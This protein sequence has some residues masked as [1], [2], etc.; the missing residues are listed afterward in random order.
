[1]HPTLQLQ[2]ARSHVAMDLVIRSEAALLKDSDLRWYFKA[3]HQS[4]GSAPSAKACQKS[5]PFPPPAL[6]GFDGT[7]TLSDSRHGRRPMSALR[8]LPSPRRVSPVT[9]STFPTC[10]A[11]YPGGPQRGHLPVTSPPRAAFP[12]PEA[13][14]RPRLHF[15][16]LLRLHLALRPARLLSRPRRPLS[17][18]SDPAVTRPNRLSATRATDFSPDGIFLHWCYTPS[19]RTLGRPVKPGDDTEAKRLSIGITPRSYRLNTAAL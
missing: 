3:H 7:M 2:S 4:L 12:D 5:G 16:G 8:P 9:C 15:R 13:G 10:H 17:Q 1:M 18:G 6:P 11:Q 19:G 14:R